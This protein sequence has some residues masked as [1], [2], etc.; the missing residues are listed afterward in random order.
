MGAQA[1]STLP[2][3]NQSPVETPMTAVA[4]WLLIAFGSI[5]LLMGIKGDGLTYLYV[6]AGATG[7]GALLV[8]VARLRHRR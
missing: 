1:P 3:G 2:T 6:G 7:L 5:P 4:G 8:V